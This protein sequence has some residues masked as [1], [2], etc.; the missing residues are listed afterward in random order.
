MRRFGRLLVPFALGLLASAH[1]APR[2]RTRFS[3]RSRPHPEVLKSLPAAKPIS[4]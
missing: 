1:Y 2:K 4:N 3:G